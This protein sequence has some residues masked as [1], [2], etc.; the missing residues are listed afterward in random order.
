MDDVILGADGTGATPANFTYDARKAFA[1]AINDAEAKNP[2]ILKVLRLA[3]R[4]HLSG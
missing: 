1:A 4:H 2:A 3:G